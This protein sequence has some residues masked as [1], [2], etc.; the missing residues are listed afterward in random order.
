MYEC[1]VPNTH[2][3]GSVQ[4]DFP[5]VTAGLDKHVLDVGF[6]D[7]SVLQSDHSGMF[8]D[9]RIE[10]IFGHNPKNLLRINFAI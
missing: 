7:R 9:L 6:L 2:A 1:V 3:R 10:D 8:V 4:I 5:L